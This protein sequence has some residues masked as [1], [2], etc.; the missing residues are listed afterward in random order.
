[1]IKA[2]AYI[3][4]Q[5]DLGRISR[6]VKKTVDSA[7]IDSENTGCVFEY[8]VDTCDCQKAGD[9]S[10]SDVFN[11]GSSRANGKR[12]SVVSGDVD[13]FTSPE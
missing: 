13:R 1:M 11:Y 7:A 4:C 5:V 2:R 12:F 10:V 8:S 9:L 6:P 3:H